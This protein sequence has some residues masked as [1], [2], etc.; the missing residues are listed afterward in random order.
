MLSLALDF[1][2]PIE[3]E[4]FFIVFKAVPNLV[5]QGCLFALP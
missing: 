4:M 3:L 2:V 5:P 1:V